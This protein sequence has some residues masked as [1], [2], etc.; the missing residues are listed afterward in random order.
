MPVTTS[1]GRLFDAVGALVCRR[2]SVSYEGQAAIELE[3][4]AGQVPPGGVA[5]YPVDLSSPDGE[6]VMA[7]APMMVAAVADAAEG[8]PG[9]EIA[10]AFHE[11]IAAATVDVAAALAATRSLS[12]VVLTG[13][14][15]QNARLSG[16]VE[17]GLTRHGLEVLVHRTV[18]P[19]DGGISIGQAAIAAARSAG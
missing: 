3:A 4:L 17:A 16:L 2:R 19:N 15:F 5:P 6:L 18:P 12:T 1:V 13:G 8:R 10:A 11:G 9:P 14:V 7:P